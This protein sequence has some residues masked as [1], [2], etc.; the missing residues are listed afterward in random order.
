MVN[1]PM[2]TAKKRNYDINKVRSEYE[3]KLSQ[4]HNDEV[5][6]NSPSEAIPE[7]SSESSPLEPENS[8]LTN[9]F[10]NTIYEDEYV[11]PD[12]EDYK[13]MSLFMEWETWER[14]QALCWSENEPVNRLIVD[15]LRQ[16]SLSIPEETLDKYRTAMK[17]KHVDEWA[18]QRELLQYWWQTSGLRDQMSIKSFHMNKNSLTIIENSGTVRNYFIHRGWITDGQNKFAKEKLMFAQLKR[19][20]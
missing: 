18:K 5:V 11:N 14:L 7:P 17:Q 16:W 8:Y 20:K 10:T 9:S 13:R 15:K 6:D 1:H 3:E 2:K 12:Q 19:L 4:Q